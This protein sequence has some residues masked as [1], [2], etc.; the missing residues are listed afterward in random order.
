MTKT[1]LCAL[2]VQP[3]NLPLMDF[4]PGSLYVEWSLLLLV[5]DP[6]TAIYGLWAYIICLTK[7]SSNTST[8][9][10]DL[11]VQLLT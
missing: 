5:T 7:E 11:W 4:C 2:F 1:I 3:T 10:H 8:P 9:I 6:S